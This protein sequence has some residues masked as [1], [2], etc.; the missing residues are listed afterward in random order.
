V[1]RR[2]DLKPLR[3]NGRMIR[4]R[5]ADVEAVEAATVGE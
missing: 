1:A 5:L 2:K 3:F 4:Y